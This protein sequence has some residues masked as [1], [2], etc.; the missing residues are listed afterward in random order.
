MPCP[1]CHDSGLILCPRMVDWLIARGSDPPSCCSH[2]ACGLCG[3]GMGDDIMAALP[4]DVRVVLQQQARCAGESPATYG[5]RII[6]RQL[7]DRGAYV[8]PRVAGA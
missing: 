4:A 6:V 8:Y 2:V 1:A 5:A 7:R 3:A